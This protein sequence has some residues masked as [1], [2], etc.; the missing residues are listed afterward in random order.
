MSI[1]TNL[2]FTQ[3]EMDARDVLS[4]ADRPIITANEMKR[5]LDSGDIRLRFNALLDQLE[6]KFSEE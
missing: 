3:Q 4:L 1:W 6:S 2:K 5:R